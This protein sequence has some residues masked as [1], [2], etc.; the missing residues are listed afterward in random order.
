M[1]AVF[2]KVQQNC[3]DKALVSFY[4]TVEEVEKGDLDILLAAWAENFL[5]AIQEN[6]EQVLTNT[7]TE[8]TA[9]AC[10]ITLRRTLFDTESAFIKT[11]G[12]EKLHVQATSSICVKFES[13]IDEFMM[14]T[15]L[16]CKIL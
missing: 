7:A 8:V 9:T 10:F 16:I 6:E 4:L 15:V 12:L 14:S 13:L 3:Q 2:G 11:N 1:L 5:Q